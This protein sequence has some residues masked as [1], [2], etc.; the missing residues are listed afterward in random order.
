MRL[1]E[2]QAASHKKSLNLAKHMSLWEAMGRAAQ[3]HEVTYRRGAAL[4]PD[5]DTVVLDTDNYLDVL[6]CD[7]LGDQH[8]GACSHKLVV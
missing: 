4:D 6:R 2:L 8:Q 7:C 5:T 1:E 3:L